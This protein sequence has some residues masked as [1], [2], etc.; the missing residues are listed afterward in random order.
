MILEFFI[1]AIH[2]P[3]KVNA[4]FFVPNA[5]DHVPYSLDIILTLFPIMRLYLLWRLFIGESFWSDERADRICREMC[6]TQGGPIFALKCE[7]KERPYI[8]I[9]FTMVLII[10]VLGFAI[11]SAEL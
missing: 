10:F 3:P 6:N 7:M 1:C 11:R 2:S 5:R 4:I 8:I 9:M